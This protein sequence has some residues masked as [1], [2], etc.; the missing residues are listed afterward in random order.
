MKRCLLLRKC[1]ILCY[2]YYYFS[3]FTSVFGFSRQY[4]PSINYRLPWFRTVYCWSFDALIIISSLLRQI[5]DIKWGRQSTDLNQYRI[6]M[7]SV[8]RINATSVKWGSIQTIMLR[9][10]KTVILNLELRGTLLI[11]GQRKKVEPRTHIIVAETND[12]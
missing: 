1:S 11:S 9:E 4:F 8:V 3:I 12:M 5:S 2:Y 10:D 6:S 7:V